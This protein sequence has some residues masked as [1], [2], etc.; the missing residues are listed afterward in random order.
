MRAHTQMLEFKIGDR[1][2]IQPEG[3]GAVVGMLT[4]YN[5]TTVT[6]VTH[7][8]QRWNVSP[9]LLRRADDTRSPESRSPAVTPLRRK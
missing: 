5:R 8:G 6:V 4:R 1:V 3:R 2:S 7:D 9:T